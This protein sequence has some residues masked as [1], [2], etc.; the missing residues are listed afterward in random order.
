MSNFTVDLT[1]KTA[2]VTGASGGIGGAIAQALL[3]AGTRVIALQRR[4]TCDLSGNIEV[5]PVDLADPADTL[6]AANAVASEEQ[7]DILVNNAG[8]SLRHAFEDFP[9][10][11]WA[12]VLQV[13]LTAVMQLCQVFGRQ[14][15]VRG[16][17]KIVNIASMLAFN[18]GYT[19]AAY[20]A[21]KGG[22][23]QLTKSLCHEWARHGVNV[24]AIAPG[25]FNTELNAPVMGDTDRIAQITARIP[26]GNWGET[27]DI[28][29]AA[30]FL[31]SDA[32]AYIH[33]V[34]LPVDGG[35]LA[36]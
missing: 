16:E 21:A 25:Y 12:T 33:G 13:D 19:A 29:K 32:A 20:S 35:F 8:I 24:N 2:V 27:T 4:T 34:T 1:G 15:L 6:R 11:D 31:V 5:V 3:D 17:G 22:V 23:V 28:A 10:D 36:V 9:L 14:M 26:S 30:L 7:V 18:G